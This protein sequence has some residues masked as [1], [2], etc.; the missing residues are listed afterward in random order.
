MNIL[1]LRSWHPLSFSGTYSKL[2]ITGLGGTEL[3]MLRH[4]K[5]LVE[6]GNQV[7]IIGITKDD[8]YEDNIFFKGTHSKIDTK[9]YLQ[10]FNVPYDLIFLNVTDDLD[11]LK[12]N[13]PKTRIVEVCQNGPH[14]KNDKH[15]DLYAFVGFG[16]FAFYSVKHKQ[17]RSKFMMLPNVSVLDQYTIDLSSLNESDQVIWVGGLGKQGLRRWADA[18]SKILKI[19]PS[20]TWK[21]CTPS[22]DIPQES[23]L[24]LVLSN[25]D[26]PIERIRIL[27]LNSA[28]LAKEIKKSKILLASLGGEDG[29]SAYLDGH[30]LGVPVLS[31]DDIIGKYS[32]PEGTG[33]RCTTKEDCFS[34]LNYLLQNENVRKDLGRNGKIW[35][36]YN[37]NDRTQKFFLEQ[38]VKYLNIINNRNFLINNNRQSDRKFSIRFYIERVF[39]KLLKWQLKQK[40]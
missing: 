34:A 7:T 12:L 36:D 9:N 24:P 15:I 13:M 17:Y 14:F 20:L 38:I 27:N 33:I 11:F 8:K 6:F 2:E 21:L 40:R 25:L 32:N 18:M 1:I 29:P 31:A 3:H 37:F 23:T 5:Y 26:L 22:Y 35:Y 30:A 28:E 4:A 19:Y 10:N 39:L 16:Q